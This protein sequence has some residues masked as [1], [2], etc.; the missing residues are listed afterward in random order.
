MTLQPKE[1][2]GVL[3]ILHESNLTC[4]HGWSIERTLYSLIASQSPVYVQERVARKYMG[5][6]YELSELI[7]KDW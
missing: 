3:Y 6:P 7:H 4:G 5:F 2:N 1:E